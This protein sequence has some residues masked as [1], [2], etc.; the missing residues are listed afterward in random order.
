MAMKYKV[1]TSSDARAL[2]KLP[3]IGQTPDVHPY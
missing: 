3:P 2:A 1:P